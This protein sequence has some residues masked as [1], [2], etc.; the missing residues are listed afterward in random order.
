[1]VWLDLGLNLGLPDYWRTPYPLDQGESCFLLHNCER[2]HPG[3]EV[4]LPYP[5]LKKISLTLRTLRISNAIILKHTYFAKI[6]CWFKTVYTSS[7]LL[8]KILTFH[9]LTRK[10]FLFVQIW[11]IKEFRNGNVASLMC[12]IWKI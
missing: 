10:I 12:P 5:Y 3:F 2:P 11:E 1:M 7:P 4:R 8:W 6:K 9:T